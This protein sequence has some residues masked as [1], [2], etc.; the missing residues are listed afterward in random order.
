MSQERSYLMREALE[1]G[2]VGV[3]LN[4]SSIDW[5]TI[6]FDTLVSFSFWGFRG[7]SLFGLRIWEWKNI[8]TG[9]RLE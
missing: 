8:Q 1:L 7:F 5:K 4:F 9:T 3:Y 2:S 6:P